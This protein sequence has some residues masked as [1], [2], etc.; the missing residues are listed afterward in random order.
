MTSLLTTPGS[1]PRTEG[2]GRF[3]PVYCLLPVPAVKEHDLAR[4][5]RIDRFILAK[6]K[7]SKAWTP[8]QRPPGSRALWFGGFIL[9]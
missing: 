8:A 9:T 4:G 6:P 7:R 3:K 1:R 5:T 2:T